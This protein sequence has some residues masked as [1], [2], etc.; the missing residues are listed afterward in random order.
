MSM[1]GHIGDGGGDEDEAAEGGDNQGADEEA[2]AKRSDEVEDRIELTKGVRQPMGIELRDGPNQSVVIHRIAQTSSAYGR[3][4]AGDVL[5]SIDGTPVTNARMASELVRAAG[6]RLVLVRRSATGMLGLSP[7]IG[8]WLLRVLKRS[9]RGKVDVKTESDA[10][11]KPP[12]PEKAAA[13]GNEKKRLK[14]MEFL[15]RVR[16]K[17]AGTPQ[18]VIQVPLVVP[19][20]SRSKM[21]PPPSAEGATRENDMTALANEDIKSA[22]EYSIPEPIL[23]ETPPLSARGVIATALLQE[24]D[25]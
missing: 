4:N 16:A 14:R 22:V 2:A 15:T 9:P 25:G 23:T 13:S 18:A 21:S 7:Q 17:A 12:E 3:L 24:A 20:Q 1:A 6:P 11:L 8:L 5:V 10:R 19:C